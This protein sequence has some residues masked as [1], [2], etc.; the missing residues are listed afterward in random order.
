MS[1]TLNNHG[2]VG[3]Q[4]V[5]ESALK[6]L[7]NELAVADKGFLFALNFYHNF[8]FSCQEMKINFVSELALKKCTLSLTRQHDCLKQWFSTF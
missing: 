5:N 1:L 6:D 2:M 3:E 8:Y 4:K 7:A